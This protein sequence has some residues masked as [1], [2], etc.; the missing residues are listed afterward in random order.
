MKIIQWT[1]SVSRRAGATEGGSVGQR[2]LLHCYWQNFWLLTL[3]NM[4]EFGRMLEKCEK[5]TLAPLPTLINYKVEN[6]VFII[7]DMVMEPQ[8]EAAGRNYLDL[9]HYIFWLAECF[10]FCDDAKLSR[11]FLNKKKSFSPS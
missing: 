2:R 7:A 1:P 10:F 5:L 6:F 9:Y 3:A 4:E 11:R 8:A